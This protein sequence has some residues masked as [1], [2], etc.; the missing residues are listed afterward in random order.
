[1]DLRTAAREAYLFALPMTEIALI[2][3]RLL[4]AG[5]PAGQFFPQKGLATPS[6]RFV[7]TPNNDTIYANAFID[8]REGAA[9][10]AIPDLGERY[11][12]LY[13]MDMYSNSIG[14]LG[15]RTTGQ[16]GGTFRLVGPTETARPGDIRSPTPWVW[17]MARVLVNGP[18]DVTAALDV[19][20]RFGCTGTPVNPKAAA[21]ANR[22]GSWQEWLTAANALLLENPP[23]A[24]DRKILGKMA[25]LGLGTRTFDPSVF[26]ESQAAEITAGIDEAKKMTLSAGFGGSKVGEWLYPAPDMGTFGQDYITRA[27]IAVAGLAALPTAE[28]MYIT[29]YSPD[30]SPAFKGE[31][32]WRLRFPKDALPPVDAF[33]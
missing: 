26:S 12:S 2:R 19:L 6:D 23:M 16:E 31:G 29:A 5:H 14:V 4:G 10:L 3:G 11:G 18:D 25:A 24:T 20:H 15:T 22:N 9:E 28:A 13:L 33:W 32:L 8:L 30:G 7:T 21:G 17:A 1:M 27:R